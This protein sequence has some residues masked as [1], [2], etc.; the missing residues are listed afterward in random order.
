MI[1]LVALI[2]RDDEGH[3]PMGSGQTEVANG[4]VGSIQGSGLDRKPSSLP[5]V[6]ECSE[7]VDRIVAVAVS[8]GEH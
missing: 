8:D 2:E 7:S 1:V 3:T 6:V 5:S 4:I